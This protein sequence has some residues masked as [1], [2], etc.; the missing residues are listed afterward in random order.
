L[1]KEEKKKRQQIELLMEPEKKE[2]FNYDP[3]DERF[4]AVFSN[5]LYSIDPTHHKFDHL[6]TG[7][8]FQELVKR[9]KK[10]HL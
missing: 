5:H 7:K 8:V 6:K 2:E 9:N 3:E 10:K 4:K 1:I